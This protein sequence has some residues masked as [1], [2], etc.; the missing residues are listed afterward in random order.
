MVPQLGFWIKD[1]KS[2]KQVCSISNDRY[3]KPNSFLN[4]GSLNLDLKTGLF[5]VREIISQQKGKK[6]HENKD[7]E[8]RLQ[9][10]FGLI[11]QKE[12]VEN[13]SKKSGSDLLKVE[14]FG[15]KLNDDISNY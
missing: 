2:G 11:S 8:S 5:D 15:I 7:L 12:Y 1:D 4:F 6:D 14:L 9:I 13:I 10:V 3:F